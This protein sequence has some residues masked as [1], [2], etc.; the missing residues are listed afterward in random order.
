[1]LL[2]RN[3]TYSTSSTTPVEQRKPLLDDIKP[4]FDDIRGNK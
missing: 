4:M 3:N 1:M 2:L